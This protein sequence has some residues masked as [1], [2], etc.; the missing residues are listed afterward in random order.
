MLGKQPQTSRGLLTCCRIATGNGD[1]LG[2][3]PHA[4][5]CVGIPDLGDGPVKHSQGTPGVARDPHDPG[6]LEGDL[7]TCADIRG[8]LDRLAQVV[9]GLA[10][11]YP[12]L[13]RAELRQHVGAGGGM[14]R[15][16]Q[17][18]SQVTHSLVDGAPGKRLPSR[19]AQDRDNPV[20]AHPLGDDQ[21]GRDPVGRS[22]FAV[23]DRCCLPVRAVALARRQA[24]VHGAADRGVH[25]FDR[26]AAG[27]YPGGG[28]CI[29]GSGGRAG[30][31]PGQRGR[32]PQ[33]DP[34]AQHCDGSGEHLGLG[35][36]PPQPWQHRL[37][38]HLRRQPGNPPLTPGGGV[39]ALGAQRV[40]SIRSSSGLPPV[41]SRQARQIQRPPRGNAA[42]TI[43][44]A[45]V[46]DS[47]AGCSRRVSGSWRS[48]SSRASS[49]PGSAGRAA[50]TSRMGS[51]SIRR[52]T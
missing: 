46:S 8:P 48:G 52:S 36:Q 1:K 17:R 26:T 3:E 31:D 43:N 25:E 41:A 9:A 50:T 24:L 32:V 35:G 15:F 23:E 2:L 30:L 39:G 21:V 5:G 19:R 45:A 33:L 16:L 13:D 7:G 4:E 42:R 14:G 27:E 34:D 11:V 29:G 38:H 12:R 20:V 22:A 10:D 47:G 28:E 37:G 49:A 51:A 40:G 6:E 18:T 44:E